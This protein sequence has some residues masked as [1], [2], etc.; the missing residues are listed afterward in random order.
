MKLE[1]TMA[2]RH[3]DMPKANVLLYDD[4]PVRHWDKFTDEYYSHLFIIPVEGG[5]AKDLMKG[6]KYD[7]PLQP[8]GG[9]SQICWSPESSEIAYTCK[10][11]DDP[12]MSTNSDIYVIPIAGTKSNNITE[13]MEGY[14]L[15]PVY[16]PDNKHIAFISMQR[17]GYESDKQR[18]FLYNRRNARIEE[19]TKD[20]KYN[21]NHPVF[22]KDGQ[23]VYFY[24]GNSDGTYQ[25]W[26]IDLKSKKSSTVTEGN[27]NWGDRGL[28]VTPD[29]NNLILSRRNFNHPEEIFSLNLKSKK[30]TQLTFENSD[31]MKKIDPVKIEAKWITSTDGAKVHCWVVYPPDFDASKK[32]PLLT[33]CQGGP[34]QMVSQHFSTGWSFLTMASEGYVIVAPN[35]RGC[36]GFGQEWTDA[37]NQDYDGQPM[38]D[39]LAATDEM[40][41]IFVDTGGFTSIFHEK[42]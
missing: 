23:N 20:F 38:Q 35:R 2:E 14:D 9:R 42:N 12:E 34:Q 21:V 36:P 7:V 40:L 33:Y 6:E 39:I 19:V 30:L 25:I 1:K 22:S 29:G 15:D 4:L 32:Y 8:F 28:L 37:I 3:K 10:K 13:G 17:P 18:L 27:Y 41:L 11:V 5:E 24:A 26:N 16:T 31:V